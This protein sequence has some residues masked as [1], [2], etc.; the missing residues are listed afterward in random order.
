[1][2]PH[3]LSELIVRELLKRA[4][5]KFEALAVGEAAFHLVSIETHFIR[6]YLPEEITPP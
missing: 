4:G 3:L 6:E 5:R 2:G 1:M